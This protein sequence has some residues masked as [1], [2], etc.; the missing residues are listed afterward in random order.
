MKDIHPHYFT[1][2]FAGAADEDTSSGRYNAEVYLL[3]H[4]EARYRD[5]QHLATLRGLTVQPFRDGLFPKWMLE[6]EHATAYDFEHSG[7]HLLRLILESPTVPHG[8]SP[9]YIELFGVISEIYAYADDAEAFIQ[10]DG[11]DGWLHVAPEMCSGCKQEH[12]E[13]RYRAEKRDEMKAL[14]GSVVQIT[15]TP[16]SKEPL[17][18]SEGLLR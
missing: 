3:A 9:G 4:R 17:A 15:L 11:D 6:V 16:L 10:Q 13:G 2:D 5:E 12:P 1:A 18:K 7:V 8:L 14:V